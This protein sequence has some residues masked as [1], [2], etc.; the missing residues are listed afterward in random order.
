MMF[1]SVF[2][3]PV[4]F[5]NRGL[6]SGDGQTGGGRQLIVCFLILIKTG[7]KQRGRGFISS[8]IFDQK[9]R[10]MSKQT[11][12]GGGVENFRLPAK[13]NTPMSSSKCATKTHI[14]E[15]SQPGDTE[16]IQ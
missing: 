8:G 16:K 10:K 12:M 5:K 15:A 13:A 14:L 7:L 1:A 4:Q 2:V 3:G 11:K 6:F 9:T